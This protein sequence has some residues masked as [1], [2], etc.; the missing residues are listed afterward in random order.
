MERCIMTDKI[1]H[2]E[3]L[4]SKEETTETPIR[5]GRVNRPT[6]FT[7]KYVNPYSCDLE[8]MKRI[9]S[10]MAKMIVEDIKRDLNRVNDK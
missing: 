5:K 10:I 1:N 2:H 8:R 7:I 9:K 6:G 4:N 3:D